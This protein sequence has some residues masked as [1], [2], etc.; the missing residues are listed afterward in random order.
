L[1]EGKILGKKIGDQGIKNK[2]K[3]ILERG[4]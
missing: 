3:E 4:H 2:G 1:R